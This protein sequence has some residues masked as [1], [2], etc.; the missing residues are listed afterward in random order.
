LR[1]TIKIIS[2][3]LLACLGLALLSYCIIQLSAPAPAGNAT[4]YVLYSSSGSMLQL[5]DAGQIDAF[6]M[7]EPVVS[8]AQLSGIGRRIATADDLPPQGRWASTPCCVLVLSD[9]TITNYP[10]ISALLS[11]LTTAGVE[12]V[13]ANP[14]LAENITAAWVFGTNPVLT[15]NGSLNPLSVE[16]HSFQNIVFTTSSPSA[17]NS[18]GMSY[19]NA[20]VTGPANAFLN[21]SAIAKITNNNTIPTLN[22]GYLPS[23]DHYAPVYQLI[24]DSDYFCAKYGYCLAPN[25][26]KTHRPSHCTLLVNGSPAAYVNLVP[27]QSGGGIMTTIGQGALDGAYVGSV[28]AEQQIGL[29]NPS[30]I[31]QT[32][33]IGGSG[34]VVAPGN[35]T[36]NWTAFVAMARERSEQK[37]PVVIGVVQSSIQETMIREALADENITVNLYGTRT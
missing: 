35:P 28:P 32:I 17:N 21:G 9:K 13:N 22:I 19:N 1:K 4:A 26:R 18:D 3:F 33:N 8:N 36:N 14:Q 11:A 29:G 27:G 2:L 6:L 12:R 20:A 30:S 37:K 23:S 10:Q 34:L 25:G 24:Q 5:L 31:I 16:E 15:P 7:W